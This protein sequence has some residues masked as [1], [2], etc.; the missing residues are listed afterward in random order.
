MKYTL[1]KY[2]TIA[3]LLS[4]TFASC[5][6]EF[7]D[8]YVYPCDL[9][10]SNEDGTPK[11]STTFYFPYG[12]TDSSF[13][14]YDILT[15]LKLSTAQEPILYNFYIEKDT[16]RWTGGRSSRHH[17]VIT[18]NKKGKQVWLEVKV[19]E[20]DYEDGKGFYF[21]YNQNKS[22]VKDLSTKD[23]NT[24]ED[25]HVKE[26]IFNTPSEYYAMID[27]STWWLEVHKK[28]F[29]G[30]TRKQSPTGALKDCGLYLIQLSG[31]S[32]DIY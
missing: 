29:Y 30:I 10:I 9:N 23:W 26:I 18:L 14:E 7:G 32:E 22:F 1:G 15:Q 6:S 12:A 3:L 19:L 31:L 13:I 11:D 2:Y 5:A 24:F 20:I 21:N 8:K 17:Y 16:Y 25:K 28:D 4:S 27:G